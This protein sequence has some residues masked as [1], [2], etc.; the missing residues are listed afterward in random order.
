MRNRM[1][2]YA[3]WIMANYQAIV[4]INSSVSALRLVSQ[5]QDKKSGEVYFVIQIV[6]KNIFPKLLARDFKDQSILANFSKKDQEVIR[7]FIPR[8][9]IQVTKCIAARTY[10]R[11]KKQFVFTIESLD[12]NKK[13][14]KCVLTNKLS[15]LSQDIRNFDG[16]DS[17]LIGLESSKEFN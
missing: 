17:F 5:G 6:G 8:E 7:Q 9:Q 1:S 2:S 16:E 12:Q 13:L 15:S 3:S 10:D 14:K 4:R 11:E